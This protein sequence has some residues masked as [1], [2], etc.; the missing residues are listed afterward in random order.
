M[1]QVAFLFHFKGNWFASL[2]WSMPDCVSNSFACAA[3]YWSCTASDLC[4]TSSGAGKPLHKNM[5]TNQTVDA[6]FL[7]Q[8]NRSQ[9][10]VALGSKEQL[11]VAYTDIPKEPLLVPC[12][13]LFGEIG[14][15]VEL[16]PLS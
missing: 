12:C 16:V 4:Y 13:Q 14:D 6:L 15:K 3:G 7:L 11:Q 1:S 5:K 10:T 9:G 8:Y 2:G